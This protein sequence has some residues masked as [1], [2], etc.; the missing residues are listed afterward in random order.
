M[1]EVRS[2]EVYSVKVRTGEICPAKVRA[3][4]VSPAQV[5]SAKSRSIE[6]CRGEVS[7]SHICLA[8][9]KDLILV[10]KFRITRYQDR[11]AGL[12]VCCWFYIGGQLCASRMVGLLM[13]FS[14]RIVPDVGT[15]YLHNWP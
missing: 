13:R 1:V 10:L 15:Q 5:R 8:E 9:I 7:P 4:E 14:G 3:D 11:K 2:A 6:V 12:D